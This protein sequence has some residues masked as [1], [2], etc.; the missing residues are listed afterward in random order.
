MAIQKRFSYS[1][2]FTRITSRMKTMP[3]S[4]YK[5]SIFVIFQYYLFF[6]AKMPRVAKTIA[7]SAPIIYIFTNAFSM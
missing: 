4:M 5:M 3:R 2:F 1:L 7:S 6:F